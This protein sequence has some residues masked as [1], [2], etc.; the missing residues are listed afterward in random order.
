MLN[1][2]PNYRNKMFAIIDNDDSN[3]KTFIMSSPSKISLKKGHAF[4]LPAGPDFSCPGATQACK[5][6][7][8]QKGRHIFSNVQK[9]FASN[10][11][12][13][14][15]FRTLNDISGCAKAL[16]EVIPNTTFF[17]IHESGD[18]EDAFAIKVW[19]EV[20][21]ARPDCRFYA[22]TRSFKLDFSDLLNKDN[23]YLWA[24]TDNF[25][26][27]DAEEFVAKYKKHDVKH[28]FGPWEKNKPIP[29]N[30]V[31]CPVTSGKLKVEGACEKCKLCVV[32]DRTKKNM[33]FI[34]H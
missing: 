9:A 2:N 17:R 14:N 24:S 10:W 32:K 18:F 20:V 22:Y 31:V 5:D 21:K 6:C 33:L 13:M 34:E 4:S 27:A 12:L 26:N 23:F 1:G 25:N 3:K 7:Y 16:L 8:A 28:A 19:S 15:S 11:K 30:A 29:Q